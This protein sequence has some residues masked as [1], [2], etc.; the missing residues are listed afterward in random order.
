M[1]CLCDLRAIED[2]HIPRARAW[3]A[4]L[5]YTNTKGI[6]S[7]DM[8][9]VQNLFLPESSHLSHACATVYTDAYIRSVAQRTALLHLKADATPA[10][11]T[12]DCVPPAVASVP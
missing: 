1:W 5:A 3:D 10:L 7:D 8:P 12:A 9:T 6:H 11:S 2:K 4:L